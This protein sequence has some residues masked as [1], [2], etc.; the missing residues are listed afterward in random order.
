MSNSEPLYGLSGTLW[1]VHLKPQEDELLSSWIVRLAHAH[2]YKTQ[3]LCTILF[4]HDNTVWNRD[5]DRLAPQEI[6]DILSRISGTPVARIESTTLRAYEGT[7][8]ERHNTGG[9]ARW[10]VPLGIFHRARRHPGLMFC[11]QCLREDAT[12]YFRRRWRLAFSTICTKHEGYLLDACPKCESPITPHRSDM[13]GRQLFPSVGLNVHCWKCG[14]DLRKSM[15]EKVLDESLMALQARMDSVLTDGYADWAGNP[16][17]HAIIFFDGFRELVAGITGRHTQERLKSSAKLGGVNLSGWPSAGLEMASLP[18]RRELFHLLAMVLEDWPVNFIRLIHEC[19]LRYADL[20]GDS[21]QRVMWY[22]DV[23]QREAGC[24]HTLLVGR[25]EAD[26]I[27]NAVEIKHGHFNADMARKLSGHDIHAY[28]PDRLPTPVSDEVYEELLTSID[29]QIAVTQD[30]IERAC[31]IRDKVMFAVGRQLGLSEGKLANLTLEQVR[32]LVSDEVELD[33]S[34]VARSPAQARAWVEWY[35]VKMRPQLKPKPEV[36][37]VFTSAK[38]R[39]GFKHSAVGKRF[40]QVVNV[41]MMSRC[42]ASYVCWANKKE[43]L[44]LQEKIQT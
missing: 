20:K 35:W 29:H 15:Q 41:G 9:T 26:A 22:E 40:Q 8:F 12:P 1:P 34:D 27:A 32:A 44:R 18:L 42:V 14:F 37:C 43:T 25:D 23:I 17:M 30:K 4:G 21:E 2:S 24:G 13:H 39:R 5:I 33:F 7:L 3:T 6:I 11:P 31:L 19:N 28:V 16:S 10:I 36:D 38:T